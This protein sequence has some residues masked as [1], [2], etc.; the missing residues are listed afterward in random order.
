[1]EYIEYPVVAHNAWDS[2]YAKGAIFE[3]FSRH[4]RNPN[5]DHVR[6]AVREIALCLSLLG[7]HRQHDA[8]RH[9][10]ARCGAHGLRV[11]VQTHDLDG[12]TLSIPAKTV[13]VD[14]AAVRL[15][16]GAPLSFTRTARG[17]MQSTPG[18]FPARFTGP[19]VEA[20]NGRHI[21]VYS[22]EDP[23]TRHYAETAAAWSSN[24]ARLNLRLAVKSDREVND[25]DMDDAN[26]I[27]F[28]TA[29]NNRVIARLAPRFPLVLDPGAADYG[30][31]FILP[32]GKHYAL[33]SSGLPWWT[34][35]DEANRGGYRYAPQT[36]RLLSTF[37][38]Y[39]LFKGSLANV[40]AEGRFGPN[41]EVSPED[42]EKI[43]AAGTVTVR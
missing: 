11:R 15:R 38:D 17:W 20:V 29:R 36:Y 40:L 3:W 35:A 37:G 9:R 7:A 18:P 43:R 21:Y 10:H 13:T 12:F 33:I 41:G 32:Q 4:R 24:R 2:A 42:A 16:A 31:L 34:G 19:I 23:Q 14:G 30:L 8:R 6:L 22:A 27:L 25:D 5:P 28:G 26:L 1:M 39:V